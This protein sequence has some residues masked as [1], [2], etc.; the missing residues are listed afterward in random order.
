MLFPNYQTM[1]MERF[2]LG[3]RMTR[4]EIS[5]TGFYGFLG[6]I[7]AFNSPYIGGIQGTRNL[8]ERLAI[9]HNADFHIL[10]IG[11]ATGYTS[12][13]IGEEFGCSVTG[14]DISEIL[15]EKAQERA[16]KRGLDNVQ[17]QVADALDLPF[18]SDT[19][20]AVFAV[21]VTALV[22]DTQKALSEY[23]RVVRPGGVVGTLD[24]FAS[25]NAPPELVDE[26]NTVMSQILGGNVG[27]RSIGEWN[28][29][30]DEVPL[31]EKVISEQY[32]DVFENPRDRSSAISATFRLLYH[33][34]VNGPLRAKFSEA[35]KLRKR[36]NLDEVAEQKHIGY[37]T[38]NGRKL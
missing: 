16:R 32:G 28:R 36:L 31:V 13:L 25:N 15:V 8:L 23:Y 26:I 30:Y 33:L 17:F 20:D 4:E 9:Q 12:C 10:E 6:Y 5:S 29:I 27:I 2:T 3:R 35:M 34:V 14:I 18:E 37:L 19:Y 11:S 24:L 38:F 21:A 7:G 22:P 1:K